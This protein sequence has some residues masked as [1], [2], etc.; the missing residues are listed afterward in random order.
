MRD[1]EAELQQRP[2]EEEMKGKFGR[3]VL[4]TNV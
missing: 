3:G 4:E 2:S 1:E